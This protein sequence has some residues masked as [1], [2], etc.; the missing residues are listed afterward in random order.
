MSHSNKVKKDE[1]KEENEHKNDGCMQFR[2][3]LMK[4]SS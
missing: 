3:K 2:N 1:Q 4:K